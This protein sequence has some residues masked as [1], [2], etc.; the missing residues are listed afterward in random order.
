MCCPGNAVRGNG[1]LGGM[2]EARTRRAIRDAAIGIVATAIVVCGFLATDYY[3]ERRLAARVANGQRVTAHVES[4][5]TYWQPH[6]HARRLV[7]SYAL[8]EREYRAPLMWLVSS[9]ED[10]AIGVGDSLGVY[11]DAEHPDRIATS[12]RAGSEGWLLRIPADGGA[13][14]L[15]IVLAA[16]AIRVRWHLSE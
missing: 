9:A 8:N 4:A 11:V 15:A 2:V 10:E 16:T 6:S 1:I 13:L 5:A 12:D 7:V 3:F 14:L